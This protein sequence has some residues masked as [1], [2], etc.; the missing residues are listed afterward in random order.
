MKIGVIVQART[1]STRLPGKVLKE[2]P[3]GSGITVLEH[4][5]NRVKQSSKINK[6]VVATTKDKADSAIVKIAKNTKVGCFKGSR[7]DVLS[8]YYFA[9]AK[10]RFDVVVRITSDCPCVDPKIIDSAIKTHLK[11]KSDY[12]SNTVKRSYPH[13]LDVEVFNF[14][15]LEDAHKRAKTK[16]DREHVTSYIYKNKNKFKI[17]HIKAPSKLNAPDVRITLDTKA[18]HML[19][20]AL[21]RFLYKKNK[22]FSSYDIIKLFEKRPWLLLINNKKLVK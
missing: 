7:D 12:T 5:I 8:R 9:A 6:V 15:V 22:N 13:G 11:E 4:A 2:L 10:D 17:T 3:S 20:S 16:Y 21:F 14:N 1:S 19:L 18:D